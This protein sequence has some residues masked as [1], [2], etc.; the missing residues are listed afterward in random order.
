MADRR[1]DFWIRETGTGQQ[2][3]QLHDRHMM[4]MMIFFRLFLTS[5]SYRDLDIPT[6]L[7]V[8]GFHLYIFFTILVS[9][10]LFMCPNQLNLW[11]LT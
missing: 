3:A 1:R 7:L 5:S 11:A 8:N 2:V 6:G 10:I 9:G 4:M